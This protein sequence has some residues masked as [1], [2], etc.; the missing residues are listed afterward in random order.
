MQK[1]KGKVYLVGAGPG[2]PGLL[3]VKGKELLKAAEVVIYDALVKPDILKWAKAGNLKIR[4]RERRKFSSL[5]GRGRRE[6]EQN[7]IN[8]LMLK[9]ARKGKTVVRLKGGDPFLFGRGGEECE[10]LVRSGIPFEVVPGVS[11]VTA[12]PAYAGIPVTDRRHTSMLTIITGHF[13]NG[14][15][16]GPGVDWKKISPSGTLVILM[17]MENFNRIAR[18]LKT[19]GWPGGTPAAIISWGT[20]PNQRVV[21]G[22]L[23]SMSEKLKRAKPPFTPPAVI[24]IGNVVRLRRKVDWFNV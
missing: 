10:H 24:V 18:R 19:E 3:T 23:S 6:K 22:T 11:S 8:R 14:S 1:K 13:G 5:Q 7:V 2:D 15:F 12:V 21:M 20:L 9:Y 4:A 16:Q 17:G